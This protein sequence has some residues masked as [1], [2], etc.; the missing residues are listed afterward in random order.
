MSD[1]EIRSVVQKVDSIFTEEALRQ[2]DGN[3]V[4]LTLEPGGPVIGMAT[5]K[6]VPEERALMAHLRVDDPTVAEFL[7]GPPPSIFKES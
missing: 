6:Y 7:K 2:Q 3:T 1:E 4:P 5:L